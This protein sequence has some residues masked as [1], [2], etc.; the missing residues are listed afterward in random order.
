MLMQQVSLHYIKLGVWCTWVQLILLGTFSVLKNHSFA[1]ICYTHSDSI[2]SRLSDYER[3]R[4]FSNI[5]QFLS[6]L[7]CAVF[8]E[9][10]LWQNN[11][12]GIVA[13]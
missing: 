4:A 12:Q 1:Q 11:R 3:A 8:T 10:L 9:F 13:S 5:A 6:K 2:F 7:V